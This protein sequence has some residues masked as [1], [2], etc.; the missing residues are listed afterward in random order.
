MIQ[1]FF[2]AVCLS[3]CST[4]IKTFASD[5][6]FTAFCMFYMPVRKTCCIEASWEQFSGLNTEFQLKI[7]FLTDFPFFDILIIR[8]F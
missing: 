1:I 7:D 4:K 5:Q 6:I 2:M 8:L 3:V